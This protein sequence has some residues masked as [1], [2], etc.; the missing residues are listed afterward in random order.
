MLDWN[1]LKRVMSG[2]YLRR[3]LMV[4]LII[5]SLLNLINQGDAL[6]GAAAISWVKLMLTYLVPFGVAS[7]GAYSALRGHG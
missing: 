2:A 3:S 1:L 6:F 5:G 4:A 7:F